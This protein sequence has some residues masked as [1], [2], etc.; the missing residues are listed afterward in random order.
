MIRTVVLQC[1][2]QFSYLIVQMGDAGIIPDLCLAHELR[3]HG[4]RIGIG[5]PTQS[6][7]TFFIRPVAYGGRRQVPAAVEV[8]EALGRVKRRMRPE[9]GCHQEKGTGAV[10]AAEKI[11]GSVRDPVGGVEPFLI[12]PGPGGEGIAFQPF[13]RHIPVDA[14]LGL[15]PVEIIVGDPLVFRVGHVGIPI[16]ME[17]AVVEL[18]VVE[19]HEVPQ[20]MDMHLSHALGVISG[21]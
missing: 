3:I 9:I 5:A 2:Y 21:L 6:S 1:V 4:S 13:V 19:A 14:D 15:Q 16:G 12:H 10:S 11:D 7:Q 20:G 18:Y 8:E 17:V